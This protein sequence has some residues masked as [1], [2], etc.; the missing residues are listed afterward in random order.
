MKPF[1]LSMYLLFLNLIEMLAGWLCINIHYFERVPERMRWDILSVDF[2]RALALWILRT[3]TSSYLAT[4]R[5]EWSEPVSD[6]E[7]RIDMTLQYLVP[8][9]NTICISFN[10]P[11][12]LWN[13]H[14]LSNCRKRVIFFHPP[15][16]P[17][18]SKRATYPTTTH[19]TAPYT[20][21]VE[22]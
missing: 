7:L 19:T 12:W 11:P 10:S 17:T 4:H 14:R 13:K 18:D 3:S 6:H 1:A 16:R 2:I 21:R 20:T 5:N 15:I 9:N 8:I 22:K